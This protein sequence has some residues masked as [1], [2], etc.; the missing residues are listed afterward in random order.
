MSKLRNPDKDNRKSQSVL[1]EQISL[2]LKCKLEDCDHSL[3]QYD[4]PGSDSYCRIHQLQLTEY[5]GMG[6][7]ERPYTFYRNWVCEDCGYD[8]REDT[9]R[10]GMIEDPFHKLRAMRGVMHGDHQIRKSDGGTDTADNIKTSCVL[11][12]MAKTYREKDYLKGTI[13]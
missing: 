12:H 5:G 3:T 13:L 6:K 2:G 11:C 8:P 9:L 1:R 10:F 7:A 4:G